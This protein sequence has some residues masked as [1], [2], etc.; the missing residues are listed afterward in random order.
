[1]PRTAISAFGAVIIAAAVTGS[2][3]QGAAASH[4]PGYIGAY[5]GRSAQGIAVQLGPRR[6]SG[7]TFRYRARMTCTDGSTF[8]DDYFSDQVRIRRGR[9][10]SR[11]SSTGGAILTIVTGTLHGLQARGTIHIIERYSEIADPMG[12]TPLAADGAIVCDSQLVHW[13]ATGQR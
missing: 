9:F 6:S 2:L 12:N 3:A 7:R 13:T 5:R 1:M 4:F 8:L 10:S 11:V